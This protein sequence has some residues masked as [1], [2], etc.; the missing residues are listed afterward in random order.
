MGPDN[1][2]LDTNANANI[3][4]NAKCDWPLKILSSCTIGFISFEHKISFKNKQNKLLHFRYIM[5]LIEVRL[6]HTELNQGICR[7]QM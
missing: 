5:A 6:V 3:D 2:K 1:A 4:V 7:R